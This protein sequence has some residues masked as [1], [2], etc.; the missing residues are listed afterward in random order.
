MTLRPASR[1]AVSEAVG[2]LREG[3]LIGLPTE[4]VYGL[5]ADA[6]NA[7][8]V[9]GIFAAKGRPRFNP[10]ICH[11]TGS[12]MAADLVEMPA[13]AQALTRHF[14]P[15]PLTLVSRRRAGAP[16]ADLVC[17]G[18]P[19]LAVR[20]PDHPVAQ[21]VLDAFGGALAAPSA[22][23]SG[24]LSPTTAAD[25]EERLGAALAMVLDGGPCGV[26][27]ESSIVGVEPERLVLLR[28]GFVTAE[29]LAKA[30]GLPI[31]ARASAAPLTAPG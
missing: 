11:V 28:P 4:T 13:A 12:D 16:V 22:N 1:A 7:R 29:A 5:A 3:R 14:W 17:A 15:G 21:A 24:K 9:A 20:A 18:L 31:A 23:P 6:A 25:V 2:A 19:T 8:A 10:L 26:G 30:A 27:L